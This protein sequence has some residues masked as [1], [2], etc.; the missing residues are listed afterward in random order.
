MLLSVHVPCSAKRGTT[1]VATYR[2]IQGRARHE[3]GRVHLGEDVRR[4]RGT[5]EQDTSEERRCGFESSHIIGHADRHR[6]RLVAR[7]T[8]PPR[9]R[10]REVG[11]DRRRRVTGSGLIEA[12]REAGS[13]NV[14][15]ERLAWLPTRSWKKML[16]SVHVPC[17]AKRG[18]TIVA[19]Y[20]PS[21]GVPDTRWDG[22]TSANATRRSR[23]TRE[24]DTS[25]ERRCGFESSQIIGHADRHRDRLVA[26]RRVHRGR[27]ERKVGDHWRAG[28]LLRRRRNTNNNSRCHHCGD[29]KEASIGRH[30]WAHCSYRASGCQA[31]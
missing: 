21:K 4:S 11:D 13:R 8:C 17:S 28:I 7:P 9:R 25:E 26:S 27:C 19:T 1:I 14:G 10:E 20:V 3:V 30:F 22:R 24:Q 2:P 31:A 5:R 12:G 6:D 15:A 16:V 23:G 18:T 29:Q